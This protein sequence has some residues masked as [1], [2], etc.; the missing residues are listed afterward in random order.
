[1]GV[2]GSWV[3]SMLTDDS[4]AYFDALNNHSTFFLQFS[5]ALI[6]GLAGLSV[7]VIVLS[8]CLYYT[9]LYYIVVSPLKAFDFVVYWSGHCPP[10]LY[11]LFLF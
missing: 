1:M 11:F 2:V 5:F 8:C 7:V 9:T 3:V 6:R 4:Y 10:I